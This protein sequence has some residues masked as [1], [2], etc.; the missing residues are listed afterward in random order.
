MDRTGKLLAG[1]SVSV[2]LLGTGAAQRGA[3]AAPFLGQNTGVTED[4]PALRQA[5]QTVYDLLQGKDELTA[6]SL[7][8]IVNQTHVQRDMTERV[9]R[10]LL[11]Q[12]K[13]SRTGSNTQN[14][15]YKYYDRRGHEG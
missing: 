6:L 10:L 11:H 7:D 14:D 9:M 8:D 13:I 2:L 3:A 15:P 12:G 4:D 5:A 1:V